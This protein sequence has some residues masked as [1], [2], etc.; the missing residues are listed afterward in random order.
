MSI[1]KKYSAK[2][3]AELEDV[4]YHSLRKQL[5]RDAS[6]P[7]N[8]RKYPNAYKCECGHGWMIP[9]KDLKQISSRKKADDK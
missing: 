5:D 1:I 2:Q 8:E 4:T 6:K 7:K 3:A 9:A